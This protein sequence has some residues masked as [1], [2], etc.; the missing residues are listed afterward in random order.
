M[1]D[2]KP[3]LLMVGG[4]T[5]RIYITTSY[6]VTSDGDVISNIKYDVTDQFEAIEASREQQRQAENEDES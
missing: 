5:G 6:K 3:P 2:A 1:S 4:L